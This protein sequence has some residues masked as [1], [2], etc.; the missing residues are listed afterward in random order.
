MKIGMWNVLPA[1]R[2]EVFSVCTKVFHP[3][4]HRSCLSEQRLTTESI[5]RRSGTNGEMPETKN[6]N[7][8]ADR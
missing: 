7:I 5:F 4:S 8:Y 1:G 3:W 6:D 2:R